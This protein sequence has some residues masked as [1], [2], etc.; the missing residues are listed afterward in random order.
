MLLSETM[1]DANLKQGDLELE[2]FDSD[3]LNGMLDHLCTS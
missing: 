2:G 3:E 1:K